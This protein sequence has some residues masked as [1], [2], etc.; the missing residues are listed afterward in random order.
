MFLELAKF[1]NNYVFLRF[2]KELFLKGPE[3]TFLD[4]GRFWES[5][6]STRIFKSERLA[7]AR[8]RFSKKHVFLLKKRRPKKVYFLS[9]FGAPKSVKIMPKVVLTPAWNLVQNRGQFRTSSGRWFQVWHDTPGVKFAPK[10]RGIG[11]IPNFPTRLEPFSKKGR[12]I[13]IWTWKNTPYER[14]LL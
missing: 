5:P 12:R 13:G 11:R 1:S 14:I 3:L 10:R 6:K 7:A 4:F 8:A 9:L 2:S